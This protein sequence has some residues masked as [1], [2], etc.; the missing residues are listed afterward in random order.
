MKIVLC[1]AAGLIP[2]IIL[3]LY[4]RNKENEYYQQYAKKDSDP[5]WIMSH[6]FLV[7]IIVAAVTYLMFIQGL[8]SIIDY[9]S[10]ICA[11]FLIGITCMETISNNGRYVY[12]DKNHIYINGEIISRKNDYEARKKTFLPQYNLGIHNKVLRVNKKQLYTINELLKENNRTI[13]LVNG[14]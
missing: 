10:L 7:V 2:G 9:L 3:N 1:I 4:M 13:R 5:N 11:S 8:N 14:Q 12:Y 6:L